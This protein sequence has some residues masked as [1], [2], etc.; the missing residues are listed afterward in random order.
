MSVKKRIKKFSRL[1]SM[2]FMLIK[3]RYDKKCT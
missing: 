2:I 3:N 1:I